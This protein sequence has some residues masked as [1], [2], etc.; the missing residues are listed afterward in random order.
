MKHVEHAA[1]GRRQRTK[2]SVSDIPIWSFQKRVITG[3]QKR[4]PREAE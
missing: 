2:T 4:R 3:M 1:E